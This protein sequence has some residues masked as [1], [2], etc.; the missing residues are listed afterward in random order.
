MKVNED[1]IKT[2]KEYLEK[3]LEIEVDEKDIKELIEVILEKLE[4]IYSLYFDIIVYKYLDKFNSFTWLYKFKKMKLKIE[5]EKP[6][7]KIKAIVAYYYGDYDTLANEI[8]D[9]LFI[10]NYVNK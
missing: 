9:L 6:L 7:S 1:C 4:A 3:T 2:V 10:E 5:K 8:T